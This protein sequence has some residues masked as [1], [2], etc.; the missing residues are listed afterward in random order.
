M[1]KGELRTRV[2]YRRGDEWVTI[3]EDNFGKAA[4]IEK[5]KLEYLLARWV[6]WFEAKGFDLGLGVSGLALGLCQCCLRGVAEQGHAPDCQYAMSK[7]L[8]G[9]AGDG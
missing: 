1:A 8:L 3:S 5:G 4:M 7:A 9:E 2:Q 6:G